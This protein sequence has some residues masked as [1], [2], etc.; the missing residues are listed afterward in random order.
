VVAVVV[1]AVAA[2]GAWKVLAGG[3]P[4]PDHMAVMPIQDLSGKDGVFVDAMQDQL[5][6]A[7]GQVP[8]ARVSPRSAVV[9]YRS[10]PE[11]AEKVARDL[12]VGGIVESTVFR[13]GDRMRINVQLV[14]PHSIRQLWSQSYELDVSDVLAAQ[15]SVVRQIVAGISKA[16]I[17][18]TL[19][20][21]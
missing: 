3:P 5:I 11:P 19:G 20:S 2:F 4:G 10:E 18:S 15:D 7:L 1:I 21:R 6:T 12:G 17:P 9:R 8:G 14:D 16:V 13:A